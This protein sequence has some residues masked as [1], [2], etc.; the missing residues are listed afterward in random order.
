MLWLLMLITCITFLYIFMDT[1]FPEES[2][3]RG[4]MFNL[5]Y[6]YIS[7]LLIILIYKQYT[8]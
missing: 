2:N 3:T 4:S 8:I 1:I 7:V 5:Y 6:K